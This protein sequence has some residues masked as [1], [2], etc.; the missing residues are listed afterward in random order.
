MGGTRS[1]L[2]SPCAV[3]K[4]ILSTDVG[5]T[6]PKHKTT[7]LPSLAPAAFRR[8]TAVLATVR[9]DVQSS[10]P[11]SHVLSYTLPKAHFPLAVQASVASPLT[12]QRTFTSRLHIVPAAWNILTRTSPWLHP[13]WLPALFSKMF[14]SLRPSQEILNK[15]PPH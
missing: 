6:L 3:V 14:F 7:L 1:W 15:T 2:G 5:M 8:K 12:V 9:E 11:C 10:S 4:P 13:S